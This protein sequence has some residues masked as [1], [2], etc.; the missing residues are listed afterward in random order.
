VSL[1][2]S[3]RA[4]DGAK[5]GPNQ[6]GSK[7][8]LTL[9][10]AA[11]RLLPTPQATDHGS[12]YATAE[13]RKANGHQTYLSHVT[14]SLTTASDHEADEPAATTPTAGGTAWGPYAAA[15]ERW[16]TLTRRAAPQPVDERGRLNPALVEWLMGLPAGHVIAVP[17][18][19]RVAQLRALGNGVVPAQA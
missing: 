7:G 8:D 15:V 11:V 18:L 12:N 9:P 16:E 3:P 4:S 10:S 2:P 14:T 1:L 5:G 6:R 17:G 13:E 19:S